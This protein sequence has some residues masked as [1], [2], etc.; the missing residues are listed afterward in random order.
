[1]LYFKDI[2]VNGAFRLFKAMLNF[3]NNFNIFKESKV[4][5]WI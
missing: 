1:M 5:L 2:L 4:V 3:V